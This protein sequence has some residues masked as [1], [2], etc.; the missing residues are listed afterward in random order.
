MYEFAVPDYPL[1]LSR[2]EET[3]HV[4]ELED[5]VETVLRA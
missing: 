4:A 2:L 1:I 3:R 5:E